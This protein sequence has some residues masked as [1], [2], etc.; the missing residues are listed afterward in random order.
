[1]QCPRCSIGD[2]GRTKREDGIKHT[3]TVKR[4]SDRALGHMV[5]DGI[6]KATDGCMVEPDGSCQHGHS[7]WLMALRL[8]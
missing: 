4:P 6:A 1:M 7:S 3:A 8:I 2:H 5:Y